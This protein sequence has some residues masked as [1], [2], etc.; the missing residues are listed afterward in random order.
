[1][2]KTLTFL[3]LF[4]LTSLGLKAQNDTI[5]VTMDP[6]LH[7]RVVLYATEGAQQQFLVFN[8]ATDGKF[9]IAMPEGSNEAMYRLVYNPKTLDYVDF[10][11]LGKPLSFSINPQANN[12][13]PIFEDSPENQRYYN[14]LIDIYQSQQELDSI[15]I[16]LFQSQSEHQVEQLTQTYQKAFNKSEEHINELLN[17]EPNEV[18]HDILKSY[19]RVLPESPINEPTEY[20][21]FVKDHYFDHVD[22]NNINLIHSS[23]LADKVLDYIFYLT[24]A[25]NPEKQNKLYKNAIDEVLSKISND[26]FRRSFMQSLIQSFSREENVEVVDHIFEKHYDVLPSG[27]KNPVWRSQVLYELSTAVTR[28]AKNINIEIEDKGTVSLYNLHDHEYYFIAFWSTTCPHCMIEIPKIH[29]FLKDKE[30]IK[31]IAVGLEDEFSKTKWKSETYRY[32]EFYHVLGLGKW[33]SQVAKNYNVHA[34]PYYFVLDK[35]KKIIA[36]PYDYEEVEA[37]FSDIFKKEEEQKQ[38]ELQKE[39]IEEPSNVIQP[40]STEEHE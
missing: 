38:N 3:F 37:Y 5:F 25:E 4:V 33:D 13:L 8:D 21:T 30:N 23:V 26:L 36:K 11:Y 19:Y 22:F 1:M 28:S 17:D 31:V 27:L 32:P 40:K 18:I 15:Q 7:Q 16:Q 35:N 6:P 39:N 29:Q 20:L 24:V 9:K 2:K 12:P 10:L 34:T 14:K